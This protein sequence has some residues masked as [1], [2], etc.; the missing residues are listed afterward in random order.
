MTTRAYIGLGS[1]LD[2]PATHVRQALEDLSALPD[3][4][5]AAA[6]ALYASAPM[7]PADQPDYVNAVAALDTGLDAHALLRALQG[8]EAAHGRV[9]GPQRWGPRTLDLDLLLFGDAVIDDEDLSV[10]HP[11]L[12]ER[13]FVLYPLS[14]IAPDLIV[15]GQGSLG[16]LLA[17]CPRDG[18]KRLVDE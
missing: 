10:P 13:D 6:S 1:N 5:L 15:P 7:G 9:R 4:H 14:E 17:R 18:L 3:S 8:I 2:H 16:E 11:G 12:P